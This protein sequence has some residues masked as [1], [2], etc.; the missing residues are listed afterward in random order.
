MW[1]DSPMFAIAILDCLVKI[2][3]FNGFEGAGRWY[4]AH[5]E[6]G[7]H[8]GPSSGIAGEVTA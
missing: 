8:R 5:Q 3:I 2:L 6:G 7:E 1:F 4:S